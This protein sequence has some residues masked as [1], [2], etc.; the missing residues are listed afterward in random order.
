MY[1]PSTNTLPSSPT[2]EEEGRITQADLDAFVGEWEN[3]DPS[4]ISDELVA[5]IEG[6]GFHVSDTVETQNTPPPVTPQFAQDVMY[7]SSPTSINP[8]T[9]SWEMSQ[10]EIDALVQDGRA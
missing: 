9:T 10:N 6:L 4:T 7:Q 3:A 2:I 1:P 8:S 5:F